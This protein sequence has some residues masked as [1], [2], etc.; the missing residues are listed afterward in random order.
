MLQTTLGGWEFLQWSDRWLQDTV[1]WQ[2]CKHW[3]TTQIKI[4]D[5]TAVE[6]EKGKKKDEDRNISFFSYHFGRKGVRASQQQ[7]STLSLSVSLVRSLPSDDSQTLLALL[8]GWIATLWAKF[9]GDPLKDI[10][11]SWESSRIC[12]G[13]EVTSILPGVSLQVSQSTLAK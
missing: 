12:E 4:T 13:G 8:V 9:K 10:P 6:G 1:G 2:R 5:S 11:M 3:P 7:G